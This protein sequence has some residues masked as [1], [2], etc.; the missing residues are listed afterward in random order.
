MTKNSGAAGKPSAPAKE[1]EDPEYRVGPGRPP[2][3]HQFKP[4]QSGNPKGRKPKL[5]SNTPDVKKM[6][7][8]ALNEKVKLR[9][10]Q[11]ERLASK[12]EIGLRQLATQVAKG[13]ARAFRIAFE[14]AKKFGVNLL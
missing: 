4:G 14:L 1:T 2:K 13:D 11:K 9:E 6:F 3:E 7:E 8:E 5:Q 12:L 10:G